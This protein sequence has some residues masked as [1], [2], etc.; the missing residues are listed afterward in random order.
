MRPQSGRS[1]RYTAE[2]LA[3]VRELY[4][5]W[6]TVRNERLRTMKSLNLRACEFVRI[7]KGQLGKKPR[8]A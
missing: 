3:R 6:H 5:R 2:E 8:A 4:E 1:S 7:G